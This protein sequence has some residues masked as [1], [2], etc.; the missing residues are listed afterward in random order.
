MTSTPHGNVP[1]ARS[2]EEYCSLFALGDTERAVSILDVGGGPASFN[3]EGTG[4]GMRVVSVD[5]LYALRAVQI[6]DRIMQVT[7]TAEHFLADYE[8]GIDQGRYVSGTVTDLPFPDGSYDLA[9]CPHL[10]F[11]PDIQDDLA[12]HLKG[13][14]ELLRVAEEVRIAPVHEQAAV[15]SR[16]MRAMRM[17]LERMGMKV[18]CR[19]GADQ[20]LVICR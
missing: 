7:A 10:F 14:R 13:V 8:T 1:E 18:E 9:L 4:Q 20:M 16:L 5:P 15:E 6:R 12:F 2:L 19:R 17:A 11:V 3:A